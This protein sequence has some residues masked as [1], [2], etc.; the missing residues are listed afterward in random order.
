MNAPAPCADARLDAPLNPRATF[1][2]NV[3]STLYLLLIFTLP[4]AG[5]F[6]LVTTAM[7]GALRLVAA[8]FAPQVYAPAFVVVA[9]LPSVPDAKGNVAGKFPR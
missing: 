1:L 5:V 4:S 6:S 8:A 3:Q 7:Y 2:F 9:G